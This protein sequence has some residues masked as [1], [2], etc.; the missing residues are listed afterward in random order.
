[1][2]LKNSN[3][4]RQNVSSKRIKLDPNADVFFDH[5]KKLLLE[6]I[7]YFFDKAG[8]F[9]FDQTPGKDKD[10]A[11]VN[12]LLCSVFQNGINEMLDLKWC[13]HPTP[14][15]VREKFVIRFVSFLKN[16]CTKPPYNISWK[17]ET[18]DIQD[19]LEETF[20]RR[21]LEFLRSIDVKAELSDFQR[22]KMKAELLK[23][24]SMMNEDQ[25]TPYWELVKALHA[26]GELNVNT[27]CPDCSSFEVTEDS[28]CSVCDRTFCSKCL[29]ITKQKCEECTSVTESSD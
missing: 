10:F 29:D 27:C 21:M 14:K 26:P 18:A 8:E 5:Q 4:L 15:A 2:L 9:E 7:T 25:S 3:I 23:F 20:C 22:S 17:E 28:Q 16:L 19:F 24:H 6:E 11:L 13:E 1:M 12:S